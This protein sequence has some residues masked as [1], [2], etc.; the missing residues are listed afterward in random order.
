MVELARFL[1]EKFLSVMKK[2]STTCLRVFTIKNC[3]QQVCVLCGLQRNLATLVELCKLQ[4]IK[5]KNVKKCIL[6]V[7]FNDNRNGYQL[8]L[9]VCMH[10]WVTM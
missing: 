5:L 10:A 8:T 2:F 7:V 3:M 9:I 1:P 4:Q 6:L